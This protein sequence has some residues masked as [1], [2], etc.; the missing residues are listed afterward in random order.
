[1][2]RVLRLALPGKGRSVRLARLGRL[3]RLE[4][5]A[6]EVPAQTRARVGRRFEL[7]GARDEADQGR[8]P[9]VRVLPAS[10]EAP[11]GEGVPIRRVG[12]EGGVE[13]RIDL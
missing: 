12:V 11:L 13:G 2:H 9:V 5:L 3:E 7:Q 4:R 10:P 1:M 6:L 8:D